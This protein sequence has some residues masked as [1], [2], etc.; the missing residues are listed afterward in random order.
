MEKAYLEECLDAGMSQR[1]IAS[2]NGVSQVTVRYW[3]GKH[4]L[5]SAN[6]RRPEPDPIAETAP[7][8]PR[9]PVPGPP[10]GAVQANG[11]PKRDTNLI[12]S[13]TEARTLAALTGA[14]YPCYVPFGVGKADLVIETDEGIKTVQCKTARVD[15]DGARIVARTNTVLRSGT[16][17]SYR[18]VVDLFALAAP[19][20]PGV[21][22][23]PVQEVGTASVT[24]RLAEGKTGTIKTMR[25]AADY[26]VAGSDVS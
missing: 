2:A 8:A 17:A 15:A 18:G 20:V 19:G 26:L 4:G 12:G 21:F 10:A 24:L 6:K 14:G 5:S 25:S 1:K 13:I 9:T 22:L 11:Q 7:S 23:V 3:L 16:T